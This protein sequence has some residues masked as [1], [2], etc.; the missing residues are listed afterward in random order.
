MRNSL[1]R[2]RGFETTE[3]ILLQDNWI[4][5]RRKIFFLMVVYND[6]KKSNKV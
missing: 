2:N 1:K 4:L 3:T 5:L 6:Y